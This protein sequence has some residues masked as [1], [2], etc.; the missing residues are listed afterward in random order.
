MPEDVSQ[1]ELWE[2]YSRMSEVIEGHEYFSSSTGVTTTVVVRWD[3]VLHRGSRIPADIFSLKL[4]RALRRFEELF[5][6]YRHISPELMQRFIDYCNSRD[7]CKA[8]LVELDNANLDGP[9]TDRYVKCTIQM[10]GLTFKYWN[11]DF[12]PNMSVEVAS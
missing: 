9:V 12:L 3:A 8:E 6:R 7:D 1:K 11:N 4:Q 2:L 10:N 5:I